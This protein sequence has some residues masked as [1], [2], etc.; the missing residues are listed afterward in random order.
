MLTR[1][2]CWPITSDCKVVIMMVV[3]VFISRPGRK[4]WQRTTRF[5]TMHAVIMMVVAAVSRPGGKYWQPT[6][7]F[8]TCMY[9]TVGLVG[10]GGSPS[11]GSWLC[12]LSPAGWLPS[13]GS[14]PVAYTRLR[15]WVP[16][17]S[18]LTVVMICRCLLCVQKLM[19]A[20]SNIW[21]QKK[22]NHVKNWKKWQAL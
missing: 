18:P 17:P 3:V 6:A 8:M 9:V 13:M 10:G 21:H 15:V 7:G 16:L 12:M 11:P 2:I 20:Q 5:M 22:N 14:A 4:Y 1:E 19:P